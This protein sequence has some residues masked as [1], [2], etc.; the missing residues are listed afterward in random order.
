MDIGRDL[1]LGQGITKLLSRIHR[2]RFIGQGCDHD[3]PPVDIL[4]RINSHSY[5]CLPLNTF[6]YSC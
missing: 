2:A 1:M 3:F 4:S 5:S 6:S